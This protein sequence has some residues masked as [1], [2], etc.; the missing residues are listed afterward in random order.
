V[1]VGLFL[2]FLAGAVAGSALLVSRKRGRK[3]ALPFAPFLVLGTL[4][5]VVWGSPILAW[6]PTP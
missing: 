4:I 1:A 2:G 6:Y 5:A 3:D